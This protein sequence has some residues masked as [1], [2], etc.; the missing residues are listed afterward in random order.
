MT[1]AECVDFL[2]WC[3]PRLGLRWAGFRKVRRQVCKRLRRRISDLRLANVAAYRGYLSDHDEEWPLLDGLCRITISRFYRDRS[4]FEVLGSEFLP[5]FA[6]RA[7]A[8]GRP[9]SAW[10]AG[11]ASGE[12]VYSLKLLWD[13]DTGRHYPETGLTVVGTD[14]DPV[15][16]HRARRGCYPSGSLRELPAGWRAAA[17]ERRNDAYC[18]RT[19]HRSGIAFRKQD[20][21]RRMPRGPFDLVL[22]R[23]LAF[24]YFAPSLQEKVLERV[25]GRLHP[26]GAL[27]IG[28]HETLP[29][30]AVRLGLSEH[31]RAIWCKS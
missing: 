20:L 1:D 12:E 10:S 14:Y 15:L 21:R 31:G 22:C 18:L 26:G 8:G 24:T 25:V 23:N 13:L 27:V 5:A 17:F 2:Q 4:I 11:C 29:D 9:L 6:H 7:G 30:P 19:D 28:G 16:L 3:L